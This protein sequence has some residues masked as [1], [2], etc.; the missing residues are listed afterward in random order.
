M[1]VPISQIRPNKFQV[2]KHIDRAAVAA[3]AA[4]IKELGYWGTLRA[5]KQGPHYELCFGHRRLEA[6]KLLKV[7]D[8]DLE[9]LELSDDDMATQALVENL[10]R[11]GLQDIEKAEALKQLI[12]R[13]D[14]NGKRQGRATVAAL[15]GFTEGRLSQLLSLV[16]LTPQS[17][18]LIEE[19]RISGVVAMEARQFGGDAMIETAAKHELP[20][21]TLRKIRQEVNAIP[22]DKIRDKVMKAVVSG[23]V[24]DP[25]SVRRRASSHVRRQKAGPSDLKVVIVGWTH[26][27]TDWELQMREVVPY[28]DYVEEVPTIAE[29]FRV[30][31]RRL[32]E[33]AKKLL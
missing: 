3:L 14:R 19:K 20:L 5:R 17:K 11:E 16:D 2:R 31:L 13:I 7:K 25:E 8:V 18:K 28:M 24:R 29:N 10:Q 32:I 22:D 1:R 4:E 26:T 33:T 21:H 12:E 9:V 6:L 30:A 27:L 23:A 15:M